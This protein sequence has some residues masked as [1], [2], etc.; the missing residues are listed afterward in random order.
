MAMSQ[1][2][3]L[4]RSVLCISGKPIKAASSPWLPLAAALSRQSSYY[5]SLCT[6][7]QCESRH[8]RDNMIHVYDIPQ[9]V[10]SLQGTQPSHSAEAMLEPSFS[11]ETNALTHCKL[12]ILDLG[13]G[14]AWIAVPAVLEDD[15]V[16]RAHVR[17]AYNGLTC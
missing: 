15:K 7:A 13:Q 17:T 12:S 14:E 4:T 11:L 16:S 9:E 5:Q 1:F 8:G 10:P 3:L 2:G 6:H